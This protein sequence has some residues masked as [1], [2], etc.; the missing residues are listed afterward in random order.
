M[1]TTNFGS[2]IANLAHSS[3]KRT[4]P[5]GQTVS[6]LAHDKKDEAQSTSLDAAIVNASLSLSIQDTNHALTLVLKTAIEGI[7]A[8]LESTLGTNAI[9]AAVDNGI[10]VS[11]EATAERVVS[12]STAFFAAYQ[13][14]NP[15][16]DFNTAL[17]Q[18]VDVISG[19]IDQGFA[20]AR[21]ILDGL[22]V[23]EGDIAS[24][25]DATYELVQNKLA[26][27]VENLSKGEVTAEQS[28]EEQ[29]GLE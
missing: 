9:Q 1:E 10:D 3:D 28:A 7:N 6:A 11:P 18:F 25:I 26:A 22:Q 15:A 19:G 17:N 21:E 16:L 2:K 12:L 13:D 4:E 14:A 5:L 23:L 8:E 20:E 27:F 24:N 29:L